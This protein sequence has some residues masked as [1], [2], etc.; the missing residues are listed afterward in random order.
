MNNKLQ[1]VIYF[2]ITVKRGNFLWKMFFLLLG[3]YLEHLQK[4]HKKNSFLVKT[5][6]ENMCEKTL[7]SKRKA[8]YFYLIHLLL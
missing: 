4:F 7:V 2:D 1:N 5:E 8:L 3:Y 6:K